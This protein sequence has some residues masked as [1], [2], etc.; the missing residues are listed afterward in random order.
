M[1][2]AFEPDTA[3]DAIEATLAYIVDDGTK[4]FTEQRQQRQRVLSP[5]YIAYLQPTISVAHRCCIPV[6]I[7]Q[8]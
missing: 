1:A 6:I 2:L 3:P 4:V 7:I 8:R 5:S